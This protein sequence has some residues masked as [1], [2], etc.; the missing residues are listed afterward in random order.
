MGDGDL[1]SFGSSQRLTQKHLPILERQDKYQEADS[2]ESFVS[3]FAGE[4][5]CANDFE[6]LK[7][8]EGLPELGLRLSSPEAVR[9]SLNAFCEDGFV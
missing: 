6:L 1:P 3:L 9:Y 2:V 8:S 5:D 7:R 4:Q